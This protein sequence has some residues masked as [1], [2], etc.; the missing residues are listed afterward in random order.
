M[1]DNTVND[2][3]KEL[4]SL[5]RAGRL[6]DVEKWIDAGKPTE[7]Q[8]KKNARKTTLLQVAVDT[9]FHSLVELVAKR[10]ASQPS[11]NAALNDAISLRRLDLIE[12]LVAN[13]AEINSVPLA[14]V[15][16]S[17]DPKIIQFFLSHGADLVTG[18][19]F[20]EAFGARVRTALRPFLECKKAHPEL[21]TALQEQL[22]CALRYFCSEGDLK[23]VSLLIWAG[24]DARSLGRVLQ[25]D[26]TSDPECHTSG[27]RE[28][29]YSGKVEV[30]KKLKPEVDRDDLHDLLHCAAVSGQRDALH[31]LLELEVSP[32]NKEN[33]G[34]SALDTALWH[35]DVF[36]PHQ[37][38][39]LRSSYTVHAAM[40]CIAEL[41][42]HGA[43]WNPESYGLTSLRK[44]LMKCQPEVTIELLQLF[45]KY[46]ACAAE[47]VHKLLGTPR[48]REH[49]ASQAW[50]LSQLGLTLEGKG[51]LRMS[52]RR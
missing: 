29:C 19:P 43:R 6:Y 12:L 37:D 24:G 36:D 48:M 49:L 20:A 2:E 4:L 31:Y 34:S 26:Y 46:N 32:N 52:L 51:T 22:D 9:G 16:L 1:A 8:A 3:T 33:G 27:L 41:L 45:R 25:K 15:L 30:I 38:G 23:W 11:K 7:I 5:C 21:A 47:Q 18:S 14:D 28:A 50:H 10:S 35:L 39:E 42:A 40:E 44:A 13:G 17:W